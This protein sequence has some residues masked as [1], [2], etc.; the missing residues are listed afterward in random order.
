MKEKQPSP[1]RWAY[2]IPI[3][4]IV[5]GL[6]LSVWILIGTG[7]WKY[8]AMIEKA[9]SEEQHHLN[10]PGSKDVTLTRTGAYGIYYVHDLDADRGEKSQVPPAI[11]CSLTSKST[12]AVMQAVPDY[13]ETNRYEVKDKNRVWVLIMS[14]TVDQPD[15]YTF[16]CRYSN[17]MHGPQT[18]VALGP[19]Y[20]WEF[21]KIAG[22]FGLALFGGMIAFCGSFLFALLIAIIIAVKRH[23][24][25]EQQTG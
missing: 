1:G 3:L 22:K 8:P 21:L 20:V 17:D 25:L 13:V 12:G 11:D 24:S 18:S 15:N 10:V 5:L 14:L 16:A 19:N 23:V 2:V 7:F 4:V 9:F 6:M